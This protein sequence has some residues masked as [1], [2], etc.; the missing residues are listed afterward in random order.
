MSH[1]PK[2]QGASFPTACA[3]THTHP[4]TL[5]HTQKYTHP[6]IPRST[7]NH[8]RHLDEEHT[9]T[10]MPTCSH[11]HRIQTTHT[12]AH[13]HIPTVWCAL[14]PLAWAAPAPVP[15]DPC[16][17]GSACSMRPSP[18][19]CRTSAQHERLSTILGPAAGALPSPD[20][21][22]S[23]WV[24]GSGKEG[25]TGSAAPAQSL[26]Q[27]GEGR[28]APG[29]WR[30][31][32]GFPPGSLRTNMKDLT[33]GEVA[34]ST[35]LGGHQQEEVGSRHPGFLLIFVRCQRTENGGELSSRFFLIQTAVVGGVGVRKGKLEPAGRLGPR[36]L[37]VVPGEWP[38]C[39]Q[40]SPLESQEPVPFPAWR[41][42]SG[43]SGKV[44][45]WENH[46]QVVQ[47]P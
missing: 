29:I 38:L 14:D 47:W 37:W 44:G 7:R 35:G 2:P 16:T 30:P 24:S 13:T 45:R 9:Y 18:S 3:C 5:R 43:M 36:G 1:I 20:R 8:I 32:P 42:W 4:C 31:G 39:V 28:D 27:G 33:P 25:P 15:R 40:M 22:L 12:H 26:G 21:F 19:N 34:W 23:D 17:R 46:R 41:S 10:Q 11:T 6:T